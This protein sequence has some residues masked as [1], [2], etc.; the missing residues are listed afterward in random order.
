MERPIR[1]SR[2]RAGVWGVL[3]VLLAAPGSPAADLVEVLPVT[4]EVLRLHFRDGHIDYNGV[5][6]D[7]TF[8]PQTENRVYAGKLLDAKAAT[9]AARYRLTSGDDPAYTEG[10]P[11][12]AVGCKAKGTEFNSPYKE[13]PFLREHWVYAVLPA[14]LRPGKTYTIEVGDLART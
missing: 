3:L 1:R 10:R 13:P 12:V 6:P 14:P 4:D 8:E 11:P 7:G 5:R 9:D 2:A